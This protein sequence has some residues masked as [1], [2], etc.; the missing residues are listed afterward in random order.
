MTLRCI[1]HLCLLTLHYQILFF[2][3]PTPAW[4]HLSIALLFRVYHVP[5]ICLGRA[6]ITV[7]VAALDPKSKRKRKN[8][9]EHKKVFSICD[10]N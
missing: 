3:P 2:V 9:K 1:A 5:Q 6:K 4:G 7:K 8:R 10:C